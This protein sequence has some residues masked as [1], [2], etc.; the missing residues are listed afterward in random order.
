[1]MSV[2][3]F[4]HFPHLWCLNTWQREGEE[5]F[6]QDMGDFSAP[7]WRKKTTE[8]LSVIH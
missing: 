2:F 7:F 1:M 8:F 5:E 6:R 4:P 3:H